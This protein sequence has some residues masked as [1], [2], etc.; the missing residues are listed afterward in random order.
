MSGGQDADHVA[1]LVARGVAVSEQP[2]VEGRERRGEELVDTAELLGMESLRAVVAQPQGVRSRDDWASRPAAGSWTVPAGAGQEVGD[3][4][5]WV[6]R[7]R[8]IAVVEQRQGDA[9]PRDEMPFEFL[10]RAFFEVLGAQDYELGDLV[11][12]EPA[13]GVLPVQGGY[14]EVLGALAQR[15]QDRPDGRRGVAPVGAI[16]RPARSAPGR[17]GCG[18]R[19]RWRGRRRGRR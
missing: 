7:D 10:D 1:Q 3:R 15:S 5:R 4:R 16:L 18:S 11:G 9:G 14:V 13:L 6:A 2:T 8:P 19:A 12:G 17:R